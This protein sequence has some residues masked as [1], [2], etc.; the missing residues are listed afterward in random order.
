MP[1]E[2]WRP[3]LLRAPEIPN[4]RREHGRFTNWFN[5]IQVLDIPVRVDQVDLILAAAKPNEVLVDPIAIPTHSPN[6]GLTQTAII[7]VA[8]RINP[9]TRRPYAPRWAKPPPIIELTHLIQAET[10]TIPEIVAPFTPLGKTHADGKAYRD[11]QDTQPEQPQLTPLNKPQ[12][13]YDPSD[14]CIH[15]LPRAGCAQCQQKRAPKP[16]PRKEKQPRPLDPFEIILPI[17]QPPP[18]GIDTLYFVPPGKELYGYQA[19]GVRFLMERSGALL[20]DEMGLGK[21]RRCRPS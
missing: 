14:R 5:P 8:H 13:A 4:A 2:G 21:A 11:S 10:L 12:V 17:L 15:G 18:T 6:L 16:S 19:D 9:D 20:A 3:L 1:L 7:E